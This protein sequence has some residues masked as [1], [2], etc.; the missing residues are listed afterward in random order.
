MPTSKCR[1]RRRRPR[2]YKRTIKRYSRGK[3]R[4]ARRPVLATVGVRRPFVSMGSLAPAATV[5]SLSTSFSMYLNG[6]GMS[7]VQLN[8]NNPNG[9]VESNYELPRGYDQ[10]A[11]MYKRAMVTSFRVTI[12]GVCGHNQTQP[13]AERNDVIVLTISDDTIPTAS[14]WVRLPELP[15]SRYMVLPARSFGM[16]Q[17]S[18]SGSIRRLYGVPRLDEGDFSVALSKDPI[19]RPIR[20]VRGGIFIQCFD[21]AEFH[22][23]FFQCEIIQRIR[24]YDP[25]P[26]SPS[27]V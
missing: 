9:P 19:L 21:T 3:R 4:T 18:T 25:I 24:F 11:S 17:M 23:T 27:D 12:K 16:R 2:A 7:L 10:W 8:L 22:N 1:P 26:V 14:D 5:V 13:N 6:P 20:K 15:L